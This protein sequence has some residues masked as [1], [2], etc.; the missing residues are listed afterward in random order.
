LSE[1]ISAWW[2]SVATLPP[3]HSD[4]FDRML[5]PQAQLE[6]MT[7]VTA[8]EAVARYPVASLLI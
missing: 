4:P 8:D 1:R 3:F 6:G 7:L 2:T 5:V